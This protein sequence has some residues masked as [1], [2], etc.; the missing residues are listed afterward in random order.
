M[1]LALV[2]TKKQITFRQLFEEVRKTNPT[3]YVKFL[4]DLDDGFGNRYINITPA[5]YLKYLHDGLDPTKPSTSGSDELIYDGMD[6]PIDPWMIM[7]IKARTTTSGWGNCATREN[8]V[9]TYNNRFY[10]S[11]RTRVDGLCLIDC[12]KYLRDHTKNKI[13]KEKFGKYYD[14][15]KNIDPKKYLGH[16]SE[17]LECHNFGIE[18]IEEDGTCTELSEREEEETPTLALFRN[19]W[20]IRFDN[21]QDIK[22]KYKRVQEFVF[23]NEFIERSG[24][25]LQMEGRKRG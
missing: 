19:H 14:S 13:L 17:A 4:V 20:Y 24:K 6:T 5:T 7:D 9:Y 1:D 25:R 2:S 11:I 16:T 18:Q 12:I 10:L 3:A 22:I 8:K 21:I 23:K 15:V